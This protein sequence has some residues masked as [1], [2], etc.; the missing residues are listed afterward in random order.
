MEKLLTLNELRQHM[1]T[2][3]E[4]VAN[5]ASYTV[6]KRSKPIFTI[7]PP[8]EERWE[9]VIDFTTIKKG[10]IDIDDLLSRL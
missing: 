4:K 3:I 10:G 7:S 9:E 5:G 1:S 6:Y 2:Y 8:I